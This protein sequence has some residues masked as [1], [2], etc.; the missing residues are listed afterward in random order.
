MAEHATLRH[1]QLG[2]VL[3]AHRIDAGL[4]LE[5]VARRLDPMDS[6]SVPKI[7]RIENGQYAV[8]PRDVRALCQVYK[9]DGAAADELV[10]HAFQALRRGWWQEGEAGSLPGPYRRYIEYEDTC[11]AVSMF[12]PV[13]VPDLLQTAAYTRML[14]AGLWPQKAAGERA[15]L[16]SVLT[17]RQYRVAAQ[18]G[19]RV[20]VV[21]DTQTV[22]RS[23]G[24]RTVTRRQ[25]AY[26]LE[27]SRHPKINLRIIPDGRVYPGAHTGYALMTLGEGGSSLDRVGFIGGVLGGVFMEGADEI[28]RYAETFEQQRAFAFGQDETRRWLRQAVKSLG[29]VT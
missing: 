7:S 23:W 1:R 8:I 28:G 19:P 27:V 10:R 14:I 18:H 2:A 9:L 17:R 15:A 24:D 6:M 12:A 3:R 5:M 21:L 4:T 16:A 22:L 20:D 25:A 29:G 26:L 13:F 11:V